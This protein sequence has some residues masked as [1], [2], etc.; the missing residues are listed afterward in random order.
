MITLVIIESSELVSSVKEA[1]RHVSRFLF[2]HVACLVMAEC[3]D[4][5]KFGL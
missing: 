4:V 2:S 5:D 3:S 1:G